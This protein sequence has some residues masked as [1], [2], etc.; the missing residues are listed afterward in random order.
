M[1][2]LETEIKTFC[3]QAPKWMQIE[4]Q[5][6]WYGLISWSITCTE[7]LVEPVLTKITIRDLLIHSDGEFE[8]WPTEWFDTTA[9]TFLSLKLSLQQ[10][11]ELFEN[12]DNIFRDCVPVDLNIYSILADGETLSE[13]QWDRLYDALAFNN[14]SIPAK[15]IVKTHRIHGRRGLTPLKRKKAFTRHRLVVN[16]TD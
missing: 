6:L 11:Q 16:K 4:I 9:I 13:E 1:D 7:D 15:R 8:D 14:P 10:Q 2:N 5:A 12:L 3:I